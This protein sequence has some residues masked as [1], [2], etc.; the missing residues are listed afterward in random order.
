V[1]LARAHERMSRLT[2][3]VEPT[4]RE[5]LIIEAARRSVSERRPVS[6]SEV[7]RDAFR[8]LTSQSAAA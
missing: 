4:D 2:V 6:V 7:A 3:T 5:A 8:R 1:I